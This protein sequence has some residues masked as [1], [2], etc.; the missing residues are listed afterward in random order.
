M[1]Y[2]HKEAKA[3]GSWTNTC[4]VLLLIVS[5]F[6]LSLGLP[7]GLSLGLS[8]GLS[9]GIVVIVRISWYVCIYR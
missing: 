4:I 5:Y 7:L 1:L 2:P 6:G 9:L 3:T 8:P